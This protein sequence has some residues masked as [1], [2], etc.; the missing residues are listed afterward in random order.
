LVW[1]KELGSFPIKA[2]FGEGVSPVLCGDQV[3]INQDFEGPSFIV[4]LDKKTGT[5]KW[6]VP[7]DEAT[8]WATPLVVG[9]G[10]KQ[11]IVVC[12][13][14]RIRSYAPADGKVLWEVGGMTVNAIPCPVA[15]T[16]R[17]YCMSGFRGSKVLAIKLAAASGDL[18][19]KPEA[20]AWSSAENTPYVP[21]PALSGGL[22]YY[23]KV[24]D[25]FLTCVEAATG[26]V[27]YA[28]K[29]EGLRQVFASLVAAGG[30]LYVAG[31]DGVTAVVKLGS[32]F[33]LLA[34]NRLDDGIIAS[35]AAVGNDLLIRGCKS[36]YCIGEK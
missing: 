16:E 2:N 36:L 12:A 6:R 14:K 21:S 35:P 29:I 27:Q 33:E 31:K 32:Q 23:L 25:G 9:Q 19:A 18:D 11:Q 15:D 4:A 20:I 26:K 10:D 1:N 30:C 13:T 24:N 8:S 3:I 28:T 7:R 5:E 34:T 22:L 17:V